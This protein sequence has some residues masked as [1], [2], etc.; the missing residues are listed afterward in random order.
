MVFAANHALHPA[1][2][3]LLKFASALPRSPRGMVDDVNALLCARS[4]P[5]LAGLVNSLADNL[6]DLLREQRDLPPD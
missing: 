1:E 3:R 4:E 2:K 5:E 6:D